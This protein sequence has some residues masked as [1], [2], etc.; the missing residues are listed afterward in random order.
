MSVPELEASVVA[1]SNHVVTWTDQL[2]AV[3][4][5]GAVVLSLAIAISGAIV[6][7]REKRA[8]REQSRIAAERA[9]AEQ[10]H[11]RHEL[12]SE[13]P[14]PYEDD[15]SLA[16]AHKHLGLDSC[17]G[18]V[19]IVENRS[20]APVHEL[21]LHT[22]R[23]FLPGVTLF[24]PGEIGPNS[25]RVFHVSGFGASLLDPEFSS[26]GHITF[27]DA[28]GRRWRRQKSGALAHSVTTVNEDAKAAEAIHWRLFHT[29]RDISIEQEW[30]GPANQKLRGLIGWSA[31]APAASTAP[32]TR[33]MRQQLHTGDELAFRLLQHL[34]SGH[35]ERIVAVAWWKW[36]SGAISLDDLIRDPR[37][38]YP[39]QVRAITKTK[40]AQRRR[41]MVSKP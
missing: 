16:N 1:S 25:R 23:Y 35:Y 5:V 37:V 36:R 4:T 11:W 30:T 18:E 38:L 27:S 14:L 29:L 7:W 6:T 19:L 21:V 17:W 20:D 24:M 39:H 41:E 15:L 28:Q 8:R 3:G 13:H 40:Q 12:C 26:A 34:P 2:T 9:Q 33:L 10:L 31:V 22:P 32:R